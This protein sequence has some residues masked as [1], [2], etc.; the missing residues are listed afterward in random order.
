MKRLIIFFGSL[1]F[2]F[3]IALTLVFYGSGYRLDV[4]ERKIEGTG[5][6]NISSTPS[7]AEVF[8]DGE[9]R[10]TT[11]ADITN[12]QPGKYKITL[13]KEGFTTWEKQI[14]IEKEILVPIE[15]YLF[16]SAPKLS[17][18][19]FTGVISPTVSPD[20]EKVAYGVNDK[21]K[22]G[23]WVMEL[24]GRNLIFDKSPQQIAKDTKS[25]NFSKSLISWSANN[26]SILST[27]SDKSGKQ[28]NYLL[29]ISRLN[30]ELVTVSAKRAKELR[31]QWNKDLSDEAVEK[32]DRLGKE[33]QAAAKGAS[34]FFVSPDEKRVLIIRDGKNPIVYDTNPGLSPGSKAKSFTLPLAGQYVWYSS[35]KHIILIKEN[36]ISIV[37][38]DGENEMSIYTESFVKNAIYLWPNG[39]KIVLTT[40]FNSTNGNKPNFYSIDL[41]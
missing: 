22:G 9:L 31:A 17:P 37:E 25:L 8:I 33:A 1:V 36:S 20:S 16:P 23:L 21:G 6:L 5:I 26:N 41:R 38:S 7:G 18:L 27:V 14:T 10:G 11:E 35:S 28:V 2:I 3:L 24:G 34:N 12:L 15:A 39:S 4:N 40:N 19:T 32:L 30:E 13:V 29:D